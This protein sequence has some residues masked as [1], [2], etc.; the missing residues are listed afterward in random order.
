MDATQVVANST[1]SEQAAAP[2]G[3]R[4]AFSAVSGV[5]PRLAAWAAERLWFTPPRPKISKEARSVLGR[6]TRFPLEIDGRQVAAWSFGS[7]RPVALMHGWGGYA[8]QLS[9]FVD[10]LV[11]AGFQVIAF[12]ALAH[13]ASPG[14]RTG[15]RLSTFFDFAGGLAA[16]QRKA[17]PLHA[18][19][20]HSGGAIATGI[21]LRDQLQVER[22]VLLAP[23]TRPRQYA[24]LF[25]QALGLD[26][27]VS[28]KWQARAL[29][30]IGLTWDELDVT[31]P[32]TPRRPAHVL[33]SRDDKEVPFADGEALAASWPGATLVPVAGL[34]HRRILRDPEV[35]KRSVE[36]LR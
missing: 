14:S 10:P 29:N 15:V 35:V 27:R 23:M 5:S 36:F 17:G 32:S 8:G 1:P 28:E 18:V 3:L 12:D 31:G 33:H 25:S 24:A 34:G 26:A 7:G 4:K 21:A 11:A 22:L 16:L 13:G 20:A 2:S 6:G 30:R 19:V 9:P